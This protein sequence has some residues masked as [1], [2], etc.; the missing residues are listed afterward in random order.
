VAEDKVFIL[1]SC[2]SIDEKP[3]SSLWKQS[4]QS[5]K[6]TELFTYREILANQEIHIDGLHANEGV[7]LLVTYVQ[8]V[9]TAE[10]FD[11]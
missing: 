4:I 8:K 6:A 9:I 3:V 5:V 1:I 11:E 2:E 10:M 7:A